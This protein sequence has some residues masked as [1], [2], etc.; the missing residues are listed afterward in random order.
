MPESPFMIR[1]D[2]APPVRPAGHQGTYIGYEHTYPQ[3]RTYEMF[4]GCHGAC[5]ICK[6]EY[7]LSVLEKEKEFYGRMNMTKE[8]YNAVVAQRRAEDSE[9]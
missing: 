1:S 3:L 5:E 4:G 8:E 9:K 6:L 7:E 2:P